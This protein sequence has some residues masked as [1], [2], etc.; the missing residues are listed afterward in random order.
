MSW[1]NGNGILIGTDSMIEMAVSIINN[2]TDILPDIFIDIVRVNNRD[3]DVEDAG[4]LSSKSSGFA[5]NEVYEFLDHIN[6][7]S[8]SSP[9][10]NL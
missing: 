2:S 10:K 8:V 3:Q 9:G 4:L 5:I 7:Q 6:S 1:T